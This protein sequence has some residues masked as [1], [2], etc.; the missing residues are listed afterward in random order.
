MLARNNDIL[1]ESS[2]LRFL[3]KNNKP[4]NMAVLKC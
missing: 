1:E 4:E 3:Y 2:D